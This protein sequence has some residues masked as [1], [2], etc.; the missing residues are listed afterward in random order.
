V[1]SEPYKTDLGFGWVIAED[2]DLFMKRWMLCME[3]E[4]SRA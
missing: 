1:E 2:D 3:L 4:Q